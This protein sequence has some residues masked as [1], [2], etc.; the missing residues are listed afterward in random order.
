MWPTLQNFFFFGSILKGTKL[1]GEV[2]LLH[3]QK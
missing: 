2:S 1:Y 3:S